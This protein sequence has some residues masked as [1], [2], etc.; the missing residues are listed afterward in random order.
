MQYRGSSNSG[1]IAWFLQRL[2]G[3][4]LVIVLGMHF[5]LLHYLDI[6]PLTHHVTFSTVAAR[7]STPFWK[8]VDLG[9]LV[10]AV[11]HGLNGIWMVVCDYIHRPLAR[12][13]LY[14]MLCMLGLA[15]IILG[16]ITILPFDLS[17]A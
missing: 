2:S 15:M 10:L 7:I 6:D 5:V 3:L 8:T 13:V 1:E 14:S 17:I 16:T 4:V 9:F 11:Y 12:V